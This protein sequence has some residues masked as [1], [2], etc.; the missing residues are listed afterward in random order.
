MDAW[1]EICALDDIPQRGARVVQRDGAIPIAL[2]RTAADRV[3]A[4]IDRCPHRGGPLSQ[5]LVTGERVVCPLHGWSIELAGGEAVAPDQG[6]AK[7]YA[8]ELRDG[9]VHLRE[10]DLCPAVT[11]KSPSPQPSRFASLPL[12]GSGST[13]TLSPVH[14]GE[15]WGEG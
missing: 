15:S 12:G 1:I 8:V 13:I 10:A 3:F 5:G 7:A 2:F 11:A 4:L 14:G 6:C 9:R